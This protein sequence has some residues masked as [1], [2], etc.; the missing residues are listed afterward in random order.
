M[1]TTWLRDDFAGIKRFVVNGMPLSSI[2]SINAQSLPDKRRIYFTL[3]PFDL[4]AQQGV[5]VNDPNDDAQVSMICEQDTGSVEITIHHPDDTRDPV[6]YLQLA[7]TINNQLIVLLFIVNDPRAPRFDVDRDWQGRPTKFGT[8]VRNLEAEA[9][10][11]QAGLMPGQVRR[12][13][14]LTR[15]LIPIF[16]TFVSRMG[17][18]MFL[19]DP[20]TYNAAI[21]FERYGCTYSQ[22]RRQMEWINREFMP[23]GSLY[24]KLDGSTP[25]RQPGAHRTVH[26]RS[27]AI[28]DGVLG[29]PYTDVKMY[30]RVGVHAG[31]N[32]FT[33]GGWGPTH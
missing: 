20:L 33:G 25:F 6:L 5:Q 2:R 28:H 13:L 7:D 4:L 23:G 10:A 9:A 19:L 31:V 26:G 17:L 15:Q 14:K 12:G 22:G 11:M 16:E 32:T 1:M 21:L 27:W 3:L 30:K 29:Q 8:M 18:K 24:N